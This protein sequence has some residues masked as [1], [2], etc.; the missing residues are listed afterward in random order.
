MRTTDARYALLGIALF[1][2]ASRVPGQT[3]TPR[4]RFEA[5]LQQF[6]TAQAAY[7]KQLEDAGDAAAQAKIFR[8]QSPH[9]VFALRLLELA[10]AHP[11]DAVAHDCLSWI[12]LNSECGPQ[13]EAPYEQAMTLLA[14]HHAGH[15]DSEK[16]FETMLESAFLSTGTYLEAVFEK[17]PSADVRGRAGLHLALFLK[18][19]CEVADRLRTLP[20]NAQNAEKFMGAA[21]VKKLAA[22]D[23]APLLR[24]AEQALVRVQREY[25]LVEYKKTILARVA[26]AE[27]FELR[28]LAV[29]KAIP[30][31]DGEDT[32][33]NKL[34]LSEQ[35]GKV[36]VLVFWGT[37]CPHC[38]KMIPQERALVKRY[39][40][41]PFALLGVNNDS[42]KEKLK[43]FFAKQDM[44][45]PSFHDPN[46]AIATR[47]NIKGWPAVFVIDAQ[48]IIRHRHL[49]GELLDRAVEEL[50]KEANAK[51]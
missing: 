5:I 22:T 26:D 40:G 50:V 37:W 20:E 27:L 25:G 43:A 2:S 14:R 31:I 1:L 23:P 45:W 34:K 12:A 6:A 10:K 7:S 28:H 13:C 4:A 47:W 42:D 49:R 17:H 32:T 33:G 24:R 51:K 30:E 8:E 46:D 15:K 29:G 19:Y 9:P 11:D 3:E 39:A 36:V 18:H 21:L 35:R 38:V 48:G 41:Q 44:T 16:H